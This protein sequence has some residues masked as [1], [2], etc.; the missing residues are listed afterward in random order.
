MS[1]QVS[2]VEV[3]PPNHCHPD[4][5]EQVELQPSPEVVS[6]SSQNVA[7]VLSKTYPSPQVSDQE[8]AEDADPPEQEYPV[9][10]RQVELQPSPEVVSPS[11]Q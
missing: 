7:G 10:I 3:E 2:E 8:S 5:T 11:S 4:S 1:F 9:S 6:P